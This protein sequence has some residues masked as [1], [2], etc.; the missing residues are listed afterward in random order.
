MVMVYAF[1]VPRQPAT[2]GVTVMVAVMAAPP[3]FVPVNAG[4]FPTPDAANPIAVFE[5]VQVN[6]PPAGVLVKV[7]APILAPLQ[8]VMLAGTVTVGGGLITTTTVDEAV[9]PP[10]DATTVYVPAAVT[11]IF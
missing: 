10:D 9:Q 7:A 3:K 11:L 8:T 6:V 4:V 1:G 5:F 2:V